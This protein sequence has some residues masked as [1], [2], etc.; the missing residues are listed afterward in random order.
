MCLG[1]L[2][3]F[4]ALPLIALHVLYLIN[5]GSLIISFIGFIFI[6]IL[7]DSRHNAVDFAKDLKT[8]IVLLFLL[9]L[10]KGSAG[11]I[12][13]KTYFNWYIFFLPFIIWALFCLIFSPV[14][15]T[16]FSKTISYLLLIIIT[17]TLF[18]ALWE[19]YGEKF[20][21]TLMMSGVAVLVAGFVM[22][23]INPNLVMY[24]LGERS[25]GALGN[26]N[27][28][29]IFSFLFFV[30][31]FL[32]THYFPSL[33]TKR[34]RIII[35]I[36]IIASLLWSG[37]RGQ[38]LAL[39]VFI[40]VLLLSRRNRILGVLLTIGV[41]VFVTYIDIDIVA[42]GRFFG[43]EHYLRVESLETGGGRVVAREFAWEHIQKN[44]WIGKGFSYTEYI[45]HKNFLELSMKGH[46][47]NAHNAFLTVW[48]DT[49][50]IGLVL[51]I[52][53]WLA[54]S[55]KAIAASPLALPF[56][57]S[58]FLSN[59]VESWLIGSLNPYTIQLLMMLTFL[60]AVPKQISPEQQ[61]IKL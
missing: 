5:R 60:I 32:V 23:I 42:L 35:Y 6:L 33:F 19:E 12:K 2:L 36:L 59:M 8:V 40:G 22:Y 45:Y 17:P 47:G 30:F 11:G 43:F 54:L 13:I 53:G 27:A 31:F 25:S 50:F 18:Y 15:L 38:T 49:G 9:F 20:L 48:L 26:P 51:F 57:M 34:A 46:E 44:Y 39:L 3:R 58:V 37:S 29:G 4:A 1:I 56:V 55:L 14:V 61:P 24:N 52:I 41:A 7:S 21:R 16:A 10:L 28:L